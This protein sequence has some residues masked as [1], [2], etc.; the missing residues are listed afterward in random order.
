MTI[1]NNSK[2][3][4]AKN[5]LLL[6]FR[7]LITMLVGLYTSRVVLNVLGISDYG[8]YN[9]VGGIITMMSFL[10]SAM[11]A[12]TQRFLSFELG[13]GSFIRL[14]KV[15]S[16]SLIIHFAIAAIVV[17]IGETLGLW[18]VNSKLNIPPE[19]LYAANCVF[20]ASI[21]T[22]VVNV[23]S[24]PFNSV[25]VAHEKMAAYAYI[26]ILEAAL[27]LIIVSLLASV[28][29]DKLIAYSVLLVAVSITVWFG[30]FLYCKKNFNEC[31][32]RLII[33]KYVFKEM[34]SFAGWS[35]FG[36]MGFTFKDQL[37]NIILNMFFGTPINAARGI[38]MQ[39]T[40]IVK[41][42]ATNFTMAINPQI[43]KQY[44][45]GDIMSSM[46]LVFAGCKYSFYLLSFVA[47]PIIINIDSILQLWLVVVPQYTVEFVCYSIF[48][49][50]IFAMS[51]CLTTAIQATG[52]VK[53]FQIGLNII[54]LSELPIA[55]IL[56]L[57]GL[58]PYAAMW[59]SL[60]TYSIALFFRFWLV[61]NY[62]EGYKFIPFILK[63]ITPCL[64]VFILSFFISSLICKSIDTNGLLS[65]FFSITI[66]LIITFMSVVLIGL[67]KPERAFL[68]KMIK[69]RIINKL[70]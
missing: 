62:I 34:F 2:R 48:I 29:F 70:Y 20:Q 65:L 28:Y 52:R 7:M 54:L 53:W 19:R 43:I 5:T 56:L 31:T 41:T 14:K 23:I 61:S 45:A 44:A 8:I 60:L 37:S 49:S 27:K 11:V 9:V 55:W 4:L 67:T 40:S 47:I 10:N 50:L 24:V 58:P 63:V 42:F 26:S 13:S 21:A 6:Y 51:G 57:L 25:I 18:F 36:N 1:E 22:F 32:F 38:G 12:S 3:R 66:C 33:D 17:I 46:R 39:V 69:N 35:V 59:P 68:Y 15:F 16:A 30:Y 64:S